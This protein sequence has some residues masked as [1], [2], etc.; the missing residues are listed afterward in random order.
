MKFLHLIWGNLVRKKIRTSLT[1]L[2]ILVAFLL[3]GLLCAI[4]QALVGGVELAARRGGQAARDRAVEGGR[5]R[6]G[7]E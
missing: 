2:S 1:L 4:K 3:F 5:R 7:V 6:R